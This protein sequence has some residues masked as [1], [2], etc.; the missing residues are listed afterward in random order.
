MSLLLVDG[1]KLDLPVMMDMKNKAV[2]GLTGGIEGLFKKNKVGRFSQPSSDL[3]CR[4]CLRCSPFF[5]SVSS[6]HSY[7][8]CAYCQ[9]T[10]VKGFGKLNSASEVAVDLTAGGTQTLKAKNIVIATGS[11]P[12]TIPNVVVCRLHLRFCSLLVVPGAVS[13]ALVCCRSAVGRHACISL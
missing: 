5:R 1:V 4:L 13:S 11:E 8:S 9:V 10:Y 12:S 6:A 2:K 7:T 3:V